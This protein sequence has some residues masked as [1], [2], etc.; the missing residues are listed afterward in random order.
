MDPL[1]H[2]DNTRQEHRLRDAEGN[3][4]SARFIML[5]GLTGGAIRALTEQ[6]TGLM[7][8]RGAIERPE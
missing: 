5:D 4:C 6:H 1:R 8:V 3:E 7:D 2:H